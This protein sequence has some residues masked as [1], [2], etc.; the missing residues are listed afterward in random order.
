V[1]ARRG[2]GVLVEPHHQQGAVGHLPR[3][4]DHPWPCG[5][6]VHGRGMRAGIPQPGLRRPEGNRLSGQQAANA[7]ERFAQYHRAGP[8]CADAAHREE[9]R[10]DREMDASRGDFLQA[11]RQRRQFHGVP[12]HR[13]RGGRIQGD[14]GRAGRG[15]GQGDVCIP[16]T[17]RVIDDPDSV[18]ARP[19]ASADK[20][21]RPGN[22][23]PHGNAKIDPQSHVHLLHFSI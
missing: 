10:G 1:P 4:F 22:R 16:T 8:R 13:V 23:E 2:D 9:P 11:L 12:A 7:G 21:G 5:Q 20:L 14:A 3:E 19:L 18:K 15:H 17:V 6:H